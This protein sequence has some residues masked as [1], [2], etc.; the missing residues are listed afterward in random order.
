MAGFEQGTCIARHISTALSAACLG[1]VLQL[2][3]VGVSSGAALTYSAPQA[4]QAA[5]SGPIRI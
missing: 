2:L 3:A 5:L 4:L 1:A